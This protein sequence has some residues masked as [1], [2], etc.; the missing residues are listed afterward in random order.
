MN[1]LRAQPTL[2]FLHSFAGRA[3]SVRQQRRGLTW[4]QTLRGSP[5]HNQ[6]DRVMA[7]SK[8]LVT[9]RQYGDNARACVSR[10]H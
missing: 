1:N 6:R 7:I 9:I 4:L 10:H 8:H 5:G 2:T 3:G